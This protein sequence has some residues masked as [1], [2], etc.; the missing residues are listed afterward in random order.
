MTDSIE[1]RLQRLE[2]LHAI[3][4]L[5][6]DYGEHLDAGDFAAYAA[7]FAIDGEVLLGPMGRASGRAEIETLMTKALAKSVGSTFHIVS[8]PRISLDGDRATSTVMWSVATLAPDGLA[9]VSM[10]GHHV[11]DLVRTAEGWRFRRRR[12]V[13]NLPS[14]M[15]ST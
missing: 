13:V 4:Q 11:D 10:V 9:R 6:I 15:P 1:A 12:G 5:F 14:A 3:N 2:D 7:L 8:S